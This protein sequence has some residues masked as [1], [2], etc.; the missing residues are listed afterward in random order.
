LDAVLTHLDR[1][2][3]LAVELVHSELPAVV[4]TAPAATY[5][6][7]LD[8][9]ALGLG[10]DPADEFLR[11]GVRLSHGPDFGPIGAGCARL[12]FATSADVLREAVRRMASAPAS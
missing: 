12:N 11:R 3:H 4:A 7:W 9:A 1:Q 6:L 2:R 10:G 8:C 5:L